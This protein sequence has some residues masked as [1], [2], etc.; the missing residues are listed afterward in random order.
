MN[1]HWQKYW[2]EY[3]SNPQ[4]MMLRGHLSGALW[5]FIAANPDSRKT[6]EPHRHIW[7]VGFHVGEGSMLG[8]PLGKKDYQPRQNPIRIFNVR[9]K[10]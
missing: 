8:F 4:E 5:I 7:T 3:Y 9:V 1:S 6:S 10:F 2:I